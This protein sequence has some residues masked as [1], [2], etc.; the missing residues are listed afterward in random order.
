MS[1][2]ADGFPAP[3]NLSAAWGSSGFYALNDRT[4]LALA[5]D[6][7]GRLLVA[8][9]TATGIYLRRLGTYGQL[10]TSYGSSGTLDIAVAYAL[11]PDHPL[12]LAVMQDG[13]CYLAYSPASN[14][15]DAVLMHITSN[16]TVDTAFGGSGAASGRISETGVVKSISVDSEGNLYALYDYMPAG[17]GPLVA[18]ARFSSTG[19]QDTLYGTSAH[20]PIQGTASAMVPLSGERITIHYAS[21]L[22]T[23]LI[24]GNTLKRIEIDAAGNF[25]TVTDDAPGN[26]SL[27]QTISTPVYGAE[28]EVLL[29]HP[30]TESF[31]ENDGTVYSDVHLQ[32]AA[33]IVPY[34]TGYLQVDLPSGITVKK[35]LA[36]GVPDG[37]WFFGSSTSDKYVTDSRTGISATVDPTGGLLVAS[38]SYVMNNGS[39]VLA[40][41]SSIFRARGQIGATVP[42]LV[43]SPAM[44]NDGTYYMTAG[45]VMISGLGP[46][47]S[48]PARLTYG[49][50]SLDGGSTWMRGWA[51]VQ[52][53]S[54]VLVRYPVHAS[55]HAATSTLSVGG[56]L[57]PQ[58]PMVTVGSRLQVTFNAGSASVAISVTP[59][60]SDGIYITLVPPPAAGPAGGGRSNVV[61]RLGGPAA[62]RR[63]FHIAVA[64]RASQGR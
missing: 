28:S 51:W 52:N 55:D 14:V 18:L 8:G 12:K 62:A 60:I 59:G 30:Q 26:G 49:E 4:T 33:T 64:G 1:A 10:D 27:V 48:V 63:A 19:L 5:E 56:Y 35:F 61:R 3:N 47:V 40:A 21:L 32:Q 31:T 39:P 13:S 20:A 36:P 23:D 43:A 37:N 9:T 16:G 46:G 7:A 41:P 6:G 24:S 2:G 53:G 15:P 54:T 42:A 29:F 38:N 25:G 17:A 57:S 44:T 50:L 22:D 45:P 58:A 34:K 11:H